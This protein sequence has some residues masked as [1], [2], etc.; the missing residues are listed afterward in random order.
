MK[1]FP[2]YAMHNKAK[3]EF[4]VEKESCS[5]INKMLI[6][7]HCLHTTTEQKHWANIRFSQRHGSNFKCFCKYSDSD[8][9]QRLVVQECSWGGTSRQAVQKKNTECHHRPSYVKMTNKIG[10]RIAPLC[11][12]TNPS[13]NWYVFKSVLFTSKDKHTWMRKMIMQ[14]R[15]SCNHV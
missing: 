8:C 4:M 6:W 12:G 2:T 5:N 7:F 9:S 11:P 1:V 3:G 10:N 15:K 13:C 14:V